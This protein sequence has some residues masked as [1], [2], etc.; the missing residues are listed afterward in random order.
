MVS[1]LPKKDNPKNP[2]KK[3]STTDF[4][5]NFITRQKSEQK[6]EE[7]KKTAKP[8]N[9]DDGIKVTDKAYEALYRTLNSINAFLDR[10]LQSN[11]SMRLLSFM[12]AV[13]LLFTINGSITNIFSTPNGGD[14]LYDVPID[15]EGLQSDYDVV[16]LPETVNVA[17]VGPT[18]DI[19]TTK[20][21]SNYN[22]YVDLSSLSEGEHT[23]ELKSEGFPSDLQVMIVPQTVTVKIT[24]KVTKT[25]EL[26]YQFTNEDKMNEKYSV[27]VESMEH[28]EVEVQGSQDNIDKITSVKAVIDLD[29]VTKNF[30]QKAKI[31]AYDRS[32]KEVDVDIIPSS[33]EVNCEVSSYSKEVSIIPRYSGQ[34]VNGYGLE[35]ISLS[36]DKVKIYGKQEFL[37]SIDEVY[38]DIDING[39]S[40]DKSYSKL[41]IQGTENI[42]K[43]E[44]NTIDANIR[45]GKTTT[46][47]I[48]G[49]PI[50]VINNNNNYEVIFADGQNT[51]SVE[52]EGV[53]DMLSELTINDFNATIDLENLKSGTNTAKVNL[54]LSKGY[55]TGRLVSPENITIT[56][57]RQ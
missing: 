19:Y 24:Q 27:S 50:N 3:D 37:N 14:Y 1:K 45:V 10:M 5:L 54:T 36:K 28:N 15:V 39:L 44:F 13:I 2:I 22:V 6:K 11:F 51:A 23:V 35:S 34:F 42:N 16:G 32:G 53:A 46:S 8:K 38:V 30:D 55:L 41:A 52:V 40:S 29:G 31:H 12:L 20:I 49:I 48:S 9:S 7:D 56:L 47:T 21:T 17:L 4:F 26:G 57:K 25:F 43:L 33:V 18:L